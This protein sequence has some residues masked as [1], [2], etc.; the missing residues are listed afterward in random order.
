MSLLAAVVIGGCTS[1]TDNVSNFSGPYAEDFKQL[2]DTIS[3][4]LGRSILEDGI[5][6]P[7]EI[8]EVQSRISQCFLDAGY[9]KAEINEDGSSDLL[10]QGLTDEEA[11]EV[12]E[13]CY[14]E[15]SGIEGQHNI[16]SLYTGM[17]TNPD[18]IDLSKATYECFLENE[19]LE[20]GTSYDDYAE[21]HA[22]PDAYQTWSELYLGS[23]DESVTPDTERRDA[24]LGCEVDPLHQ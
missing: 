22:N 19:F 11:L 2:Y 12:N 14:G 15:W 4:D 13:R 17:R 16:F 5:I 3:N 10:F 9:A 8:S 6:T 24:F 20:P 7:A 1:P 21:M 18:N 23:E